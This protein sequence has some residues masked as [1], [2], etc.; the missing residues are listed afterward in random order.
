MGEEEN[1]SKTRVQCLA[2]RTHCYVRELKSGGEGVPSISYWPVPDNELG[3]QVL[4]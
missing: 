4:Q 1:L 2:D 3:K